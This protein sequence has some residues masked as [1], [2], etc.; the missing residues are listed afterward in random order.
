VGP[1]DMHDAQVQALGGLRDLVCD[2][3][4]HF[5]VP[6]AGYHV[7]Q[8]LNIPGILGLGCKDLLPGIKD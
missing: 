1:A 2:P 6:E 4:N 3:S 8:P 7:A 5:P